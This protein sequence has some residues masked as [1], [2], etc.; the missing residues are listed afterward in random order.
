MLIVNIFN[1]W[2]RE[3]VRKVLFSVPP[4]KKKITYFEALKNPPKN[5]A[6]KLEGGGGGG[7]AY[8]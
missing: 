8:V 7:R 4:A 6:T 3:A 1:G 2:I 5:V